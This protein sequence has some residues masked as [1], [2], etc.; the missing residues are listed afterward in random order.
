[1]SAICRGPKPG[2]N[3][4]AAH[5]VSTASSLT[6]PAAGAPPITR[7]HLTPDRALAETAAASARCPATPPRAPWSA[8]AP[9]PPAAPRPPPPVR[10]TWRRPVRSLEDH[11]RPRV[12]HQD[13]TRSRRSPPLRGRNPSI[14]ETINGKPAD[15]QMRPRP[16]SVRAPRSPSSPASTARETS[17]APGSL[18]PGSAR[19]R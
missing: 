4:G 11:R 14:A 6:G 18:M 15:N 19:R 17:R 13:R 3:P 2:P 7:T 12:G 8:R 16:R 9:P 5:R 10:P 1:M